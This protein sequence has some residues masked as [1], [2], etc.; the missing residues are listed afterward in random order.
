[1]L[2]STGLLRGLL[3]RRCARCLVARPSDPFARYCLECGS[4]VPPI[5]GCRLPPPEGAQV[6]S[7]ILEAS[8]TGRSGLYLQQ[9]HSTWHTGT[10]DS[11]WKNYWQMNLALSRLLFRNQKHICSAIPFV[12]S[13]RSTGSEKDWHLL[14]SVVHLWINTCF[15]LIWYFC[16]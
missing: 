11:C 1:M 15:L 2:L 5:F 6:S 4:S 16:S 10:T 8:S 14:I 13:Q 12:W 9:E 3:C 7:R